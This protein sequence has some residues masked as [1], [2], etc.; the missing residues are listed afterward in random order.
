M[1]YYT[2]YK[3][4]AVPALAAGLLL[5]ACSKNLDKTNPN[6]VTVDQYYKTAAELQSGTNAIYAVLHSISL[7]GREWFFVHDLRSDDVATGGGQLEAPRNQILIGATDP[8]N[9][10]MNSVWDAAYTLIHRA[11]TVIEN[12]PNVT[13]NPTLRDECVGEAKFLRAWAYNEL[14][15]MWGAVPIYTQTVSTATGYQPRSA[16]SDV[17]ALIEKDLQ[18]A[19]AVLPGKSSVTDKGRA[20]NA[21]AWF[22]LARVLMQNGDYDG[23]RTAL[24]KIPT[25]GADG[26]S[27]TSRYLDN[28]EEE[29]EFN[30]ESVFEVVF[31][32]KGNNDFNWAGNLVGDGASASVTTVRNQEYCPVAW[33]N[34]IPSNRF[35][36][37]FESTVNGYAKTDPRFAYSVY[38]TGDKINNNTETLTDAQQNGNSSILNGVTQKISWRKYMLLYKEDVSYHPGGNNQR[39]FRYGEVLLMLAECENELGNTGAAVGYL[40]QIRARADVAMP[41][42]PT[43][44]YP[45]GTKTEVQKALMHEKTVEM[46]CEE[47]RNIDIIRWRKKGYFTGGDP[48]SYFRANRDELLPIPQAEIDNNPQLA[49]GG[50]AKQNPGY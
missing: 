39:I 4:L 43:A 29:T 2:I 9:A 11:N 40:N 7:V 48:L 27:L 49:A 32:D 30:N 20:T 37:E 41:A 24:L 46:G 31:A 44:Q 8:T 38:Q 16:E 1:R 34:L 42:Y 33:R 3:R 47:V 45:T 5:A 6:S 15:T 10:V 22:L 35:L 12:A 17:Y 23:A 26:Y 36:A 50:I 14:V 21:A 13:D 19:A 28:F 18:E 25:S